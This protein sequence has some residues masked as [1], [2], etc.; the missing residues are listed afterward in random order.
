MLE[1]HASLIFRINYSRS[2][3]ISSRLLLLLENPP[4]ITRLRGAEEVNLYLC[5]AGAEMELVV[6]L[7]TSQ[8]ITEGDLN[9]RKGIG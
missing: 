6:T 5:S 4:E 9:P 2:L 7:S 1:I 3:E 8:R